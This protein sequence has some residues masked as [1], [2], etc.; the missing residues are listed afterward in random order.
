MVFEGEYKNGKKNGKGK[1]FNE[2]G[3]KL[4][5]EGTYL[6]GNRY[7]GV[8]YDY[9]CKKDYEGEYMF[10]KRWNGK[11]YNSEGEVF[12]LI[13]NGI[14]SKNGNNYIYYENNQEVNLTEQEFN[15][16]KFTGEIKEYDNNN[17]LLFE[18][19]YLLG[20]RNGY[21]IEY[22]YSGIYPYL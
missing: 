5:F 7:K 2:E 20:K 3:K 8:E 13:K 6:N 14:N 16:L 22:D 19:D 10:N 17:T 11:E 9:Y 4:I 21:G 1:E 12:S 18:G 15:D